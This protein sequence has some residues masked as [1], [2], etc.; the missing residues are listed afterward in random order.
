MKF[1]FLAVASLTFM[2]L[3]V[4]H[5]PDEPIQEASRSEIDKRYFS[6]QMYKYLKKSHAGVRREFMEDV[7][8]ETMYWCK[9]WGIE[10]H[11]E[12]V[13]CGFLQESWFRPAARGKAGERGISQTYGR[14]QRDAIK[15]LAERGVNLAPINYPSTQIALGVTTFKTKLNVA[16]GDPWLA[17]ERY[18]G[19]GPM[20]RRHRNRVWRLHRRIYHD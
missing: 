7:V 20:A 10:R 14:T 1:V 11:L 16:K 4:G 6:D 17:V 9:F 12:I 5:F 19:T 3:V 2:A 15:R 8:E 18:N 13:L